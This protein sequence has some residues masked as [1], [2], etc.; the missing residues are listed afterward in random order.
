MTITIPAEALEAAAKVVRRMMAVV[1]PYTP[2]EIAHAAALALLE[3]WPG[4]QH[5]TEHEK[6]VSYIILPFS[7][8]AQ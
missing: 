2:E 5:D 1:N 4:V 6:R 8:E 3:N 7:A